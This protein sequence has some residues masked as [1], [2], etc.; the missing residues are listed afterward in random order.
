[1]AVLRVS[2]P[3]DPLQHAITLQ[4]RHY[5]CDGV[6]ITGVLNVC[7]GAGQRKHQSS[8]SLAFVRGIHRWP[9]NSAL[10]G[11]VTRKVFSFDGVMLSH[12]RWVLPLWPIAI[13]VSYS[14]QSQVANETCAVIGWNTCDSSR[15]PSQYKNRLSRYGDSHDKDKTLMRPPYIYHGDPYAGKTTSVFQDG[16]Q[17]PVVIKGTPDIRTCACEKDHS[18]AHVMAYRRP[19]SE[20]LT[21]MQRI[22]RHIWLNLFGSQCVQPFTIVF[23]FKL[24]NL[25]KSRFIYFNIQMHWLARFRI[26]LYLLF[27]LVKIDSS[28]SSDTDMHTH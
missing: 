24:T 3:C 7:S 9:V 8:A 26:P 21:K 2:V 16:S 1:M 25:F 20:I 14:V 17:I 13:Q 23:G 19:G 27:C 28:R 6:Q 15:A 4:W 22:L 10:K 12:S 18:W 11:P 5:E